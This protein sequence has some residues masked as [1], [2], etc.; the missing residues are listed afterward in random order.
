MSFVFLQFEKIHIWMIKKFEAHE[1]R[2]KNI[3][4]ILLS[5]NKDAAYDFP[6]SVIDGLTTTASTFNV[7]GK[8]ENS[9]LNGLYYQKVY[10]FLKYN[11]SA[12]NFFYIFIQLY[13]FIK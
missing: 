13:F 4:S 6:D 9:R 11:F 10:N 7:H 2:I 1:C 8:N 5:L 12:L 3:E